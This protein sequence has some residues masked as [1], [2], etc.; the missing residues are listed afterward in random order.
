MSIRNF[1]LDFHQKHV[2]RY[3]KFVQVFYRLIGNPV[4]I[5]GGPAAVIGD[6]RRL[7][8]LTEKMQNAKCKMQS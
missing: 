4:K 8:P 3:P 6:E 7:K 5:G 1:F 2:L